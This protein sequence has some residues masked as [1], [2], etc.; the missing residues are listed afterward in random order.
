MICGGTES[1]L[2]Q[3]V[4]GQDRHAVGA[5]TSPSPQIVAAAKAWSCL[6]ALRAVISSW[7]SRTCTLSWLLVYCC[8]E[9]QL[10]GP[11]GMRVGI[12]ARNSGC[13][14][15]SCAQC[16][17]PCPP[18]NRTCSWPASTALAGAPRS[19][20]QTLLS[21]WLPAKSSPHN[22]T[23]P[24]GTG[25]D[26]GGGAGGSCGGDDGGS[27]TGAGD[28]RWGGV[29]GGTTGGEAAG[30]AGAGGL[31]AGGGLRGGG[32]GAVGLGRPGGGCAARGGGLRAAG[33]GGGTLLPLKLPPL[34]PLLLLLLLLACVTPTTTATVTDRTSTVAA[35]ATAIR[36]RRLS[37][38]LPVLLLCATAV[39]PAGA[40]ASSSLVEY[41][42]FS[43]VDS[44]LSTPAELLRPCSRTAACAPVGGS[45]GRPVPATARLKLQAWPRIGGIL[46]PI[47]RRSWAIERRGFRRVSSP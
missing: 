24:A 2:A 5:R 19:Y 9:A 22:A 36:A 31:L 40:P 39:L 18:H 3:A 45:G 32:A 6:L 37:A 12:C 26:A 20:V 21:S 27:C 23:L 10:G 47:E 7:P 44:L 43:G 8:K 41:A 35:I 15:R 17:E 38:E 13:A 33:G 14:G 4:P 28:G 30:G 11:R 16:S 1:V 42:S 25:N 46:D 29:G 34:P